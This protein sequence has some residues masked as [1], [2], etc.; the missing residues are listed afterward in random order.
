MEEQL[1]KLQHSRVPSE[2]TVTQWTFSCGS[3]LLAVDCI[4]AAGRG[5]RDKLVPAPGRTNRLCTSCMESESTWAC[6]VLLKI[7]RGCRCREGCSPFLLSPSTVNDV[8]TP[9]WLSDGV[10][11]S[12]QSSIIAQPT[13]ATS[14]VDK[15]CVGHSAFV[16]RYRLS[17]RTYFGQTY[18][19]TDGRTYIRMDGR[20]DTRTNG[21]TDGQTDGR[22]NGWRDGR[23]DGRTNGRIAERTDGRTNGR[24]KGR[25]DWR[26]NGR[27]VGWMYRR[28][29]GWTDG[30]TDGRTDDRTDGWTDGRTDVRTDGRT[31]ERIAANRRTDGNAAA[32]AAVTA[33]AAAEAAAAAAAAAAELSDYQDWV[34][35]S[36]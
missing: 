24:P 22:T 21:R 20:T 33:V 19:R 4:P 13:W 17:W 15:L 27:T 12:Y 14:T 32:A 18:I 30:W 6:D 23:S 16:V 9:Q 28:T 26:S 7:R 3:D 5:L 35:I 31:D 8:F 34:K 10:Q 36:V 11:P 25:T 1:W 29:D 2:A